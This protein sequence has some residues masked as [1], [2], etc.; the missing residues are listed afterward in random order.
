MNKNTLGPQSWRT[1]YLLPWQVFL[2]MLRCLLLPFCVLIMACC[3]DT[4]RDK[5][6]RMLYI[7]PRKLPIVT[8]FSCM[9]SYM[10]FLGLLIVHIVDESPRHVFRWF[11]WILLLYVV[12]MAVEEIYQIINDKWRYASITNACDIAMIV[13]FS[14]F[15]LV[16][17]L[18][19]AS[20]D[21]TMRRVS[22]YVFAVAVGLSFLRLLYYMQVNHKLGPILISFK[23]IWAEV[24][25][26]VLI[27]GI[28]LVAFG[29]AL[30][31]VYNAGVYTADF[32]N[33]TISLPPLVSGSVS[34]SCCL[35]RFKTILEFQSLAHFAD[36]V[37]V[38]IWSNRLPTTA[39]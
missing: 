32:Q 9:V 2:F 27:L 16:R 33:G 7:D 20:D 22:E 35:F 29:T 5:I 34:F 6:I 25:S 12:A 4:A 21:L 17:L 28:V 38:A 3:R 24:A 8:F 26:F 37:L 15:F 10:V 36:D 31:V 1:L 13:C 30:A 18:E 19:Q 39:E 14:T 11:D 23:A